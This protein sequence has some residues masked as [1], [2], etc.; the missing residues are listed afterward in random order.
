MAY[1]E[2]RFI[3]FATYVRLTDGAFGCPTNGGAPM[4]IATPADWTGTL[5]P[6]YTFSDLL[7]MTGLV[8]PCLIKAYRLY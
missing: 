2:H 3:V 4:T 1:A 5:F 8:F 6:I 7:S